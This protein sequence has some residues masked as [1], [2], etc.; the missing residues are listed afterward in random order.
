M[1]VLA[2]IKRCA[3]LHRVRFTFKA[4]DERVADD[5]TELEVLE[6][7]VNAVRVEKKLRSAVSLRRGLPDYLYVIKAP[8]A[9][10]E[11]V[12]TKGK[13]VDEAGVET[14]YLLISAKIAV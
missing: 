11:I 10:R 1:D 8:T 12:Y 3:L 6:S 13:F 14:Y 5:L 4:A 9:P 2:R 7:L